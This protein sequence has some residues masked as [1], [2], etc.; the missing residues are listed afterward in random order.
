M[1]KI[2][3]PTDGSDHSQKVVKQGVAFAK[4][5]SAQVIGLHVIPAF[6]M[7]RDEGDLLPTSAALKERVD[8]QHTAKARQILASVEKEAK[9]AGIECECVVAIN[10]TIYEEIIDTAEKKNCD[11]I[12]MA[13]HGH[14]GMTGM[15]PGSETAKVLTHTKLPVL[16]LR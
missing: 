9:G 1:Y 4:A 11:L 3:F 5:L 10:D 14:A 2:L 16:V 12:I 8:E 15:L 13:S 6:H 7:P